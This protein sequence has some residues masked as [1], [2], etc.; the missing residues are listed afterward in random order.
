MVKVRPP[1]VLPLDGLI[2]VISENQRFKKKK[3]GQHMRLWYLFQFSLLANCITSGREIVPCNQIDKPLVVY[4][5]SGNVMT[6][7]TSLRT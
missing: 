3:L 1:S 5:F 2:D 6:S 4:E 7:I